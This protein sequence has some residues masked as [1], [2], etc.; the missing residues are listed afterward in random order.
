[1]KK[2][3]AILAATALITSAVASVISCGENEGSPDQ[4]PLLIGKSIDKSK[5]IDDSM[6]GKFGF[7]NFYIVGDSLSDTNGLTYLIDTKFSNSIVKLNVQ[8][9]GTYGFEK[10]GV[11]YS[12]F[13]NGPTAPTILSEELGFGEMKPSNWLL[14]NQQ[15]N[16][17]KNYSVGGATA[18]KL[19]LPTGLLL[20]DATI[21]KQTEALISQ[22]QIKNND[23]VFFEIGGNDLFSLVGYYGNEA[24][25]VE[26]LNDSMTRIRN[27]LFNLLNNGIKNIIFMTPPR[28]DFPPIYQ[29]IFK[30]DTEEG[31]KHAK[32]IIDVCEEYY[33]KLMDVLKE[34]ESYYLES[35]QL[36][37]M[38]TESDFLEQQFIKSVEARGEKVVLRK[39]FANNLTFNVTI[40][41]QKETVQ[42]D[43]NLDIIENIK[44]LLNKVKNDIDYGKQNTLNITVSPIHNDIE[45]VDGNIDN[46]FFDDIMHPTKEVHKMVSEILLNYAKELS[47]KWK[48]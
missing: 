12:A 2:L 13:T 34:V 3:L 8:L 32:Y 11:H 9:G 4:N 44:L 48:N 37:D 27:A 19:D 10:D 16:Y 41:D 38:Y 24:K 35:I 46:Y 42:G 45:G 25:Q 6:E 14:K 28:M 47:K 7:T 40:N 18:A 33:H 43:I 39:S 36:Y 15:Q 20:N 5:A 30:D 31:K 22:H 23:L 26:F 21:D 17:G 1:M 29:N